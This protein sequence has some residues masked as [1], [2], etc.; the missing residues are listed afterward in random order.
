MRRLFPLLAVAFLATPAHAAINRGFMNTKIA[1]CENFFEFANGGWAD[2]A[3][4]PGQ[5][6][7]IGA[8]REMADRN[9]EALRKVLEKAGAGAASEKDPAVAKVGN[10]FNVLMDSARAERDGAKPLAASFAR[11][12]KIKDRAGLIAEFGYFARHAAGAPFAFGAAPDR[13][14]SS[15]NIGQVVQA[16][17]G[18][19]DRD[20]YFK[21]DP[22]SDSTRREYVSIMTRLLELSGSKQA[23]KDAEAVMKLE[24]ALAESSMNRVARRNPYATF[25][26]MTVADLQKLSPQMDWAAFFKAAGVTALTASESINVAQPNFVKQIGFQIEQTPIETWRAYLKWN[27]VRGLAPWM[28]QAFFDESFRMQ[29]ML[30][31][32]TVPLP[33]WKRAAGAVDNGLGE[34]L[35]QAYVATEFPP[36]SKA[37][38][39]AMVENLREAFKERIQSRPWMSAETKKQ[40][41]AKLD[42]FVQKIGYPDR[43]R[44]Y[45]KLEIDPKLSAAEN[46]QRTVR[47]EAERNLAKINQPV[48]RNEWLMTPP[49]V[50]AYYYPPGNEI[51]FPAGILQ[52]PQFDAAADEAENYGAIGMV[53]GHELTHGFD[54]Q[55]RKTDAQGNLRDWW[56]ADD[57]KHFETEA[58]KVVEQYSSYVGV[59]TMRINGK[60]TLGENIADIGGLTLAFHAW[61]RSLG[62]KPAPVIDGFT[63][64]QRF[65]LSYA[66]AWR[67]KLRPETLRTMLLTDPH[68][69]GYWRVN[70]AVSVNPDFI[71]AFGC[72]NGQPMARD[73]KPEIW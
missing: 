3:Q 25:N 27:A 29:K 7:S 37:R 54:D 73:V 41:L 24:T 50:N 44:D 55:G 16:G 34:A 30:A 53:I 61:Q 23:A 13:R 14:N 46:L 36:A 10:F 40:A 39:Q 2:T 58:N 42:A 19:P 12:D 51:V 1:P 31:G 57:A 17:L 45:S 63:G 18:L 22:K 21:T 49:T 43:W 70:G 11:I 69:P 64:E 56:T 60:L 67:R 33:R 72:Q 66:Q 32:A 47:F 48:D 15:R 71:K 52:P 6:S 9:Q 28:S 38:V 4:I 59:D 68:S 5:Y 26:K 62:G 20:Y 35:G 8:G 65:F